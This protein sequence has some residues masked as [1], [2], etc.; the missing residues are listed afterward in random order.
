M[1]ECELP[2]PL[3]LSAADAQTVVRELTSHHIG[4][5]GLFAACAEKQRSLAKWIAEGAQ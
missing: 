3:A 5:M 1:V 2:A 4:A